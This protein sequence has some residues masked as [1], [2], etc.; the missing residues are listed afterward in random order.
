MQLFAN[1]FKTRFNDKR[2]KILSHIREASSYTF[3]IDP[4]N[5]NTLLE[6]LNWLE[7]ELTLNLI[8]LNNEEQQYFGYLKN[9][10]SG[11]RDRECVLTDRQ[12]HCLLYTMDLINEKKVSEAIHELYDYI[13]DYGRKDGKP[14]SEYEIKGIKLIIDAAKRSGMNVREKDLSFL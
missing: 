12:I 11:M 3:C 1:L 5:E 13:H 4:I 2:E 9:Y 14:L 6:H 7:Q 8:T 10:V